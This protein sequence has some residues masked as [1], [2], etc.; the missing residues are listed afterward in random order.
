MPVPWTTIITTLPTLIDT[1]GRLFRK[2]GTPPRINPSAD[3]EERLNA[4][5]KQL[6]YYES[7][8]ADQSKLLKDTIEQLQNVSVSCSAAARRI[9]LAIAISLIALLLSAGA[10][11]T[12]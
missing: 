7:L 6:E 5:I 1:A 9:N 10:F 8:Q 11:F 2:T 4:A 12:R 3:H